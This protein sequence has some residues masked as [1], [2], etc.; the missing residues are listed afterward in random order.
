MKNKLSIRHLV[1]LIIPM[2]IGCGKSVKGENNAQ[3]GT[4]TGGKSYAI[5]TKAS[6]IMWKGSMLVGANSH[7]GYVTISKGE[8]VVKD[9][10]I[11]GGTTTV[12][13]NTLV[14]ESHAGDNNL[15]DHLKSAD[16]FD[17]EKFPTAT[18]VFTG[19]V[20]NGK[21]KNIT[22]NLTIKGIT[23]AVNFPAKIEVDKGTATAT[24]KLVIDRTAWDI[25][26]KSGRFHELLADQ[27]ISDSIE[28]QVSIVAKNKC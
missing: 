3:A 24:G 5:D 7:T 18:F 19:V 20:A 17:V 23:H 27:T 25:R 2:F 28:F 9:S 4:I 8:L 11:V 15:I 26:Y 21:D 10:T 13:M 12:D 14:D 22:G 1:L 6:S 16:F